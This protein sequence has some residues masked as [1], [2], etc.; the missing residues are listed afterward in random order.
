MGICWC[1]G[2]H[3]EN[4]SYFSQSTNENTDRTVQSM[5]PAIS[6]NCYMEGSEK[7][8]LNSL[9]VDNLVLETLGIIGTLV[10]K[11]I[12]YNNHLGLNNFDLIL[13]NKNLLRLCYVYII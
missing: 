2:K 3:D 5:A 10:D 9:T 8:Y 13:V 1:K 12:I 4:D 6:N 11:Y 7:E